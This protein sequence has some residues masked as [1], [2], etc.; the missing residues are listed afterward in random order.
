MAVTKMLEQQNILMD[1]M[2]ESDD[3]SAIGGTDPLRGVILFSYM[4]ELGKHVAASGWVWG[5]ERRGRLM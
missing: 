4:G 3:G 2:L 1:G 5:V